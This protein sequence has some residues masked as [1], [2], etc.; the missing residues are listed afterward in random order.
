MK[1]N[2]SILF[3]SRETYINLLIAAGVLIG[4][5]GSGGILFSYK[6]NGKSYYSIIVAV[7]GYILIFSGFYM[8][9]IYMNRKEKKYFKP[10]R[11]K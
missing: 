1:L 6:I 8:R 5:S 11:K 7:I 10:I 2:F 4:F 3:F 9:V